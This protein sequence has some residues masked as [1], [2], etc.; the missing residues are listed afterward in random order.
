[1]TLHSVGDSWSYKYGT[2]V[3]LYWQKKTLSYWHCLQ[4]KLCMPLPGIEAWTPA[5]KCL[6]HGTDLDTKNKVL[7]DMKPCRL[8]NKD[9][10]EV[11]RTWMYNEVYNTSSTLKKDSFAENWLCGFKI[12]SKC[13]RLYLCIIYDYLISFNLLRLYVLWH[14]PLKG[15]LNY[16][17]LHWRVGGS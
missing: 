11:G 13:L 8:V 4:N 6:R 7:S 5:A 9:V 12:C 14:G 17:H 2:L 16:C 15:H 1:M 10:S 3:E